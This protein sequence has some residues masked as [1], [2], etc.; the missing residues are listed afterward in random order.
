MFAHCASSAV[1]ALYEPANRY[2]EGRVSAHGVRRRLDHANVLAR[3][4]GLDMAAVGWKP[5]VD[6][7]LGRVTKPRILE[8]VREA[9]G[10]QSVQLIDHLKKGDMARE[11]ERLLEGTG[12]PSRFVSRRSVDAKSSRSHGALQI[13]LASRRLL[14]RMSP[15][16]LPPI[17]IVKTE[18][19]S[20][21][22]MFTLPFQRLPAPIAMLSS[23]RDSRETPFVPFHAR[24]R[25][26]RS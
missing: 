5:T 18:G 23:V 12:C 6:N 24:L 19:K 8:A 15:M 10:E 17:S 11:A 7:Y 13:S 21:G 25:L 26:S 2:N 1:N 14:L 22:V 9:K 16:A 3:A 20:V 4:V